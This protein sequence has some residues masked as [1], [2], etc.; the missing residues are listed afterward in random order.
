MTPNELEKWAKKILKLI[1]VDG[2]A[3]GAVIKRCQ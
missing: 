2:T 1:Q 3:V